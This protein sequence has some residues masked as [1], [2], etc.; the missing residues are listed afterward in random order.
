MSYEVHITKADHWIHSQQMPLEE[1]DL[2]KVLPLLD[3]ISQFLIIQGGKISVPNPTKEIIGKLMFIAEKIGARVQGDDGEFYEDTNLYP[4][5]TADEGLKETIN[6]I[7]QLNTSEA[8]ETQRGTIENIKVNDQ[9]EHKKY[10]FGVVV[11]IIGEGM[12]KEFI[13]NFEKINETKRMLAYFS[14]L[15]IL[16]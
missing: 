15:K 9:I 4:L 16:K 3:S 5:S 14:P 11:E 12:D 2:V 7:T 10:G 6:T 1:K 8:S 13:I